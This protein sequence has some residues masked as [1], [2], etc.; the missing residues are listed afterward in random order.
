MFNWINETISLPAVLACFG[1]LLSAGGAVWASVEQNKS[2]KIAESRTVEIQ[3]LN[4]K[5][6]ALSEE[7]K[8]LAKTGI[9]SVT[10]GDGFTYVDIV[11][12]LYENAF[13]P[14]ISTDSKYPQYDIT[15][16]FHDEEKSTEEQ[17]LNPTIIDLKTLPAG[18]SILNRVPVFDLNGKND[19]AKFNI[20]IHA[21]NGSYLEELH[22]RKVA[23]EW[24]SAFQVYR[25][26]S[27]GKRTLL[28]EHGMPGYPRNSD[29]S[30]RL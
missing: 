3:K 21:R 6:L 8:D 13:V 24:Y 19:Y 10:G 2:Q 28:M 12:G 9:A 1:A 18:Q 11:K 26:E 27:D 16:R 29:N 14:V 25:N 23:G 15:I 17:A 5:I 20:F 22:L 30:L 4:T 7:N